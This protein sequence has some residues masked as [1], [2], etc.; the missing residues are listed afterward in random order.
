MSD[1]S[2]QVF[3]LGNEAVSLSTV[4]TRKLFITFQLQNL[5]EKGWSQGQ[6]TPKQMSIAVLLGRVSSAFSSCQRSQVAEERGWH[7][8]SLCHL[9]G[10]GQ[11]PLPEVYQDGEEG[12]LGLVVEEAV[13]QPLGRQGPD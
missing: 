10:R 7:P 3:V 12:D 2:E 11:V 4:E 13:Q 1:T 5:C 8:H 9:G 6:Q